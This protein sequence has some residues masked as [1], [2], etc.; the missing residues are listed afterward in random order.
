MPKIVDKVAKR[1][2]IARIAMALFAKKGFEN[3]SIREITKAAGMGKGTF[4]DY[5]SN[6]E[7]ILKEIVH[8]MFTDWTEAIVAKLGDIDDPLQQL[9]TLLK[10]GAKLGDSFE[11]LMILYMDIWQRSVSKKGSKEFITQFQ[12]FLSESKA[13]VVGIIES[14]KE[15][16]LIHKGVDSEVIAISLIALIDGLCLHYMI[17]KPNFNIDHVCDSFFKTLQKGMT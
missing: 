8:I 7:E 15:R 17:L 6:K 11:Q 13:S 14:A 2:E 3:T 5:F 10:E 1:I 16:K 12:S 4:Y 9:A